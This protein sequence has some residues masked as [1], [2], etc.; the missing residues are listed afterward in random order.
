M[1]PLPDAGACGRDLGARW[2]VCMA[3]KCRL[4]CRTAA[5]ARHQ[6]SF[7]HVPL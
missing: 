7:R 3:C 4:D 6:R 1:P 5:A 2:K